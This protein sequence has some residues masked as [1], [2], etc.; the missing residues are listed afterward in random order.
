MFTL[1]CKGRLVMIE[2]PLVMGIL[3][4]NDD[5]FYNASRV[6][7]TGDAALKAEQMI[8]GGA[9][10]LD[11][12][13]QSTRPGSNR[14]SEEEEMQRVIPV[15]EM[16]A[17]KSANVILSID[18]YYASVAMG[19]VNA[20]ASLV[21]DISAG[22]MDA[23]MLATVASLGVPYICMHM[24]GE[25][26][27]MH[28]DPQYE[29]ITREV[30]DFF[31]NKINECRLAG[32]KD[33]IIDPGFGFGKTARHNLILLRDLPVFNMLEKPVMTGI[34]RKSTI[35]KTLHIAVEDSL[36]GTTVFHTIALQNGATILRVHDVKEAKE[37]VTLFEAYGKA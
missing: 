32:I 10:I 30:L 36:N 19:A 24:K 3:N 28:H 21:N 6:H 23:N 35:Y 26:G 20:G 7:N 34:S 17:K 2:K 27:T 31:I 29:N 1:N 4:I 13:G 16:L 33:I 12:G 18:T 25:P 22:E 9:D 15:I 5:S 8:A 11:I 14:V 37:A